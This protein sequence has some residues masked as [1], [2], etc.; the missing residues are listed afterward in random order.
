MAH[1]QL[2]RWVIGSSASGFTLLELILVMSIAILL[3]GIAVPLLS[4]QLPGAQFKAATHDLAAHARLA[5]N[6]A[7]VK[8]A[9]MSLI[10]DVD[11]RTYQL[12][13][14][15]K[16]RQLPAQI[17]LSVFTA[18]SERIDAHQGAIRFFADGSS[19]GGRIT[20]SDGQRHNDVD[21]QWLTGKV[22]IL[23]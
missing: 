9:P 17:K 2:H 6:L 20:L 10:I 3:L 5:R 23:E 7:I 16:I 19:T 18:E 15:E 12:T 22:S 14:E 8:N 1:T 13:A 11:R 4:K 21:I